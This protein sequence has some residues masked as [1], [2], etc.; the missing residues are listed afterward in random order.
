M[1]RVEVKSVRLRMFGFCAQIPQGDL[2]LS[3]PRDH[4]IDGRLELESTVEGSSRFQG[5]FASHCEQGKLRLMNQ[6]DA[7]PRHWGVGGTIDSES[8]LRTAV[9][10]LSQV[11]APPP[12][13]WLV[14]GPKSLRSPFCGLASCKNQT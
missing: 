2:R 8:A 11:D 14:G 4:G 1:Q 7:P 9:A 13:P 6:Q 3:D 5:E 10:L 12:A